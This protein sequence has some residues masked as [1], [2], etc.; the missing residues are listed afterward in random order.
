M[1][2][3]KRRV[4]GNAA[5]DF[6]VDTSCI[7]CG[8]SRHYAPDTFGDDGA[9]A[10][11][12]AQPSSEQEV[13]AAQMALLACPVAAIGTSTKHD[14]TVARQAF[15]LSLADGVFVTGYNDR[16]SYGA[17]SYFIRGDQQNWLV[18]ALSCKG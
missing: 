16:A 14:L 18:D 4:S 15:P 10:F 3:S 13:L 17:H 5:G 12:Q 6:F 1:A 8:V 7:N 9:H 11:V 2:D